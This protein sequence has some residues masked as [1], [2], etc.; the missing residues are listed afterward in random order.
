MLNWADMK[1]TAAVSALFIL[2]NSLSGFGGLVVKDVAIDSQTT[3]MAA[4]AI[5]GSLAGAY[6]GAGKFSSLTLKRILAVVLL[7]A[8]Y[9]LFT[10]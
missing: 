6:L 1:Q 2:V 10:T 3:V 8:S 7:I 5:S 9:K 4:V